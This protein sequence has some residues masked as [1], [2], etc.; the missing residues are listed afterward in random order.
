LLYIADLLSH[1]WDKEK[2]FA[3]ESVK[4]F[5]S[6][7]DLDHQQRNNEGTN[8]VLIILKKMN[9]LQKKKSRDHSTVVAGVEWK[10]IQ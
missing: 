7:Q 5:I 6:A 10:K 9:I 3:L 4:L 1:Y 2:K 8:P